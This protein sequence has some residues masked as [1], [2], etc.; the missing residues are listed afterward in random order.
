MQLL[1]TWTQENIIKEE[2]TNFNLKRTIFTKAFLVAPYMEMIFFFLYSFQ[3]FNCI[4]F[5][6]IKLM[7]RHK[8]PLKNIFWKCNPH[9]A[10][11]IYPKTKCLSPLLGNYCYEIWDCI[12]IRLI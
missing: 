12:F 7:P 2:Q 5:R 4:N 8:R 3:I 9:F 10:G 6:V 11:Q 1:F